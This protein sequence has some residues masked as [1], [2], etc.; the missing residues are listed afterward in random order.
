MMRRFG[1]KLALTVVYVLVNAGGAV[2][3]AFMGEMMHAA[4]HVVL[5]VPGM[6]Y[7]SRL[8]ARRPLEAPLDA[9]T[10]GAFPNRLTNLEQ[11][12]DA[13][14]IEVERISEGQRAM[15]NLLV[16]QDAGPAPAPGAQPIEVKRDRP[17]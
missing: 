15:T 11:S 12:I 4:L 10:S 8:V 7:L 13:V 2:Y 16:D 14:A 6:W 1:V 5:L 9:P 3:A 17:S